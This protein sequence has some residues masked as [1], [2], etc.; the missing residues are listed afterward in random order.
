MFLFTISPFLVPSGLLYPSPALSGLQTYLQ[1]NSH[2]RHTEALEQLE[3]VSS[4]ADMEERVMVS[5]ELQH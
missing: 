5:V 3:N 1:P 4:K 2:T